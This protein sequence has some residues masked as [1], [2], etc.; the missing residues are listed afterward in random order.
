MFY[1]FITFITAR[2]GEISLLRCLLSQPNIDK[3]VKDVKGNTVL[4]NAILNSRIEV[5]RLLL[6]FNVILDLRNNDGFNALDLTILNYEPVLK[7]NASQV[8][9]NIARMLVSKGINLETRDF[10]GKTS[11]M[12]A[13]EKSLDSIA[14]DIIFHDGHDDMCIDCKDDSEGFTAL[15]Y[16]VSTGYFP[17]VNYLIKRGAQ[18]NVKSHFSNTPAHLAAAAGFDRLL[19]SLIS[20]GADLNAKNSE[21]KTVRQLA[22]F[23]V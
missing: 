19:Q 16:A 14:Y 12:Y 2:E 8:L 9:D 22:R 3:N 15:H 11:L 10:S 7:S 18:I 21:G 23:T 4:M 5:V 13:C 6:R 17:I 20:N 1:L